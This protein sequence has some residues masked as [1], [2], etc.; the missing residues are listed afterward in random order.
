MKLHF[1]SGTLSYSTAK[2][3]VTRTPPAGNMYVYMYMYINIEVFMFCWLCLEKVVNN[4]RSRLF[5]PTKGTLFPG[6]C[7]TRKS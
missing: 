3:F 4:Q 5:E 6:M 7:K 1:Y 2:G